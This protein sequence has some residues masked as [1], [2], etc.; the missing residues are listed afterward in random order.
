MSTAFWSLA[1]AQLEAIAALRHP[2]LDGVF[3]GLTLL[4]VEAFLL[5]FVALGYWLFDRRLF[6]RATAMLLIA[7]FLNTWLKGSF[8]IPRPEVVSQVLPATGWSFPSGHAQVAGAL[9]G[10]LAWMAGRERPRLATVLVALGLG[11]AA[12]RP[13]LGVHYVHDV[14]VG[15]FLGA[16]QIPLLALWARSG[17]RLGWGA[18]LGVGALGIA[19]VGFGFHPSVAAT[20]AR[21]VGAGVGLTVG[22]LLEGRAPTGRPDSTTARVRLVAV[23][24]A[25]LLALKLGLGAA[26]DAVGLGEALAPAMLR[27]ALLGAWIGWGAPRLAVWLGPAR[28]AAPT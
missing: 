15:F 22:L 25:G 9:W 4:G 10:G 16:L 23:G 21:L 20:G 18:G 13:Y 1:D 12:S 7:A 8:R 3:G 24:L 2:V 27:Y 19:W 14:I 26:I 28:A 5:P 6:A 17:V 11:V